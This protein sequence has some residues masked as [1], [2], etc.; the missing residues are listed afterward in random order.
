MTLSKS[1]ISMATLGTDVFRQTV[2]NDYSVEELV[3]DPHK[4]TAH[5]DLLA[6]VTQQK[7]RERAG[8]QPLVCDDALPEPCEIED[9]DACSPI[10]GQYL[11]WLLEKQEKSMLR[12][13][14]AAFVARGL[15]IFPAVIP[16]LLDRAH[17]EPTLRQLVQALVNKR[18]KWLVYQW[19]RNERWLF[20]DAAEF[21][22][23][24]PNIRIEL[25]DHLRHSNPIQAR[26]LVEQIWDM[27]DKSTREAYLEA[28]EIRLSMDDE[29]F[30]ERIKSTGNALCSLRAQQLLMKL[31]DSRMSQNIIEYAST[32]VE[33]EH[34]EGELNIRIKSEWDTSWLAKYV[35]DEL[36]KR[37][38]P[39]EYYLGYIPPRLWVERCN[40]SVHVLLEA[41]NRKPDLRAILFDV[42]TVSAYRYRD[43]EF[44]GA[45]LPY[46]WQKKMPTY[47]PIYRLIPQHFFEDIAIQMLAEN[48][49]PFSHHHR[50][51]IPL[52][53]MREIWS[54]DLSE[55]FL[56]KLDHYG[57]DSESHTLNLLA[58]YAKQLPLR[59]GGQFLQILS[60]LYREE[61]RRALPIA[62][63]D[64][65][66][67]AIAQTLLFRDE[68]LT[69]IR[70][71]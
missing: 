68:M 20:P 65:L 51:V 41:I 18:M 4:V 23:Y 55:R 27:E 19:D 43:A 10:V 70:S 59:L 52:A 44:A 7:F 12:E 16:K 26:Q 60:R 57:V 56:E 63:Q 62:E 67:D 66:L 42:L 29:P 58:G 6:M 37:K 53:L 2:A 64:N 17:D 30:L 45:L 9:T 13:W 35:P 46:L 21:H 28:F 40:V 24:T 49:E 22:D 33:V 54:D 8:W 36:I 61:G 47:Q 14:Q 11:F 31:P 1:L 38:R 5:R 71:G 3:I 34:V 15:H 39:V 48:A 32:L 25:I 69:A 50:V